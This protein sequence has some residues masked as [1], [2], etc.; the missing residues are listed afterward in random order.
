[1][2]LSTYS[3][4]QLW[5]NGTRVEA[6][7]VLLNILEQLLQLILKHVQYVQYKKYKILKKELFSIGHVK[8]L[9]FAI[10]FWKLKRNLKVCFSIKFCSIINFAFGWFAICC[11]VCKWADL[12]AIGRS[13]CDWPI[14]LQLFNLF[15][16]DLSITIWRWICKLL[17]DLRLAGLFAIVRSLC[18]FFF[19]IFAIGIYWSSCNLIFW[20]IC[21]WLICL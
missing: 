2:I 13:S 16:S 11:S 6:F 19:Y 8:K 12:Y 7:L 9:I 5:S 3:G 17:I 14:C 4:N 20:S 10:Y 18:N 21:N 1:M 15:A